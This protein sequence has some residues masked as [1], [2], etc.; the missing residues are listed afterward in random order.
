MS[1][2]T[3]VDLGSKH[4]TQINCLLCLLPRGDSGLKPEILEKLETLE[5]LEKLETMEKLET[6]EELETSEKLMLM[7][8]Q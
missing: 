6:L 7:F 8:T 5:K 1:S 2:K 4:G 3:T